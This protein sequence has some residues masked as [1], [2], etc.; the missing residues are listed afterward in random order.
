MNIGANPYLCNI[1]TILWIEV[2][3]SVA[4]NHCSIIRDNKLIIHQHAGEIV[5]ANLQ[6]H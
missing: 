3:S 4:W 1:T 2:L 5:I 6:V